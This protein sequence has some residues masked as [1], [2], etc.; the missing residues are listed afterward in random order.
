MFGKLKAKVCAAVAMVVAPVVAMAA[1]AV[2]WSVLTDAIDFG[3]LSVGV[4]A[5]GAAM[6]SLYLA[7]KGVRIIVG[8]VRSA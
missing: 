3:T 5:A 7:I 4:L 1:P 8:M 6:V 2:D